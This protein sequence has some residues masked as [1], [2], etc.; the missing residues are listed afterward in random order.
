MPADTAIFALPPVLTF[1]ACEDL[2]AALTRAQGSDLVIDGRD[3]S[4]L[5]GL[6]AQIL[7]TASVAWAANGQ[8]LTLANASDDLRNALEM[9]ALWPLPEKQGAL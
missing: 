8:H 2:H 3:V 4:R 5:G 6:A 7:A 1:E 9:L